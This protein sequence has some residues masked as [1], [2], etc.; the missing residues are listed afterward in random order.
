MIRLEYLMLPRIRGRFRGP[1]L[2]LLVALVVFPETCFGIG[3]EPF[4]ATKYEPGDF[5]LV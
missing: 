2:A 5:I 3:H 1:F 4:V